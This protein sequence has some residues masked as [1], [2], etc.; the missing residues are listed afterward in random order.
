M[1]N[2]HIYI[3]GP[4][5]NKTNDVPIITLG[6]SIS[7]SGNLNTHVWTKVLQNYKYLVKDPTICKQ[8]SIS[9]LIYS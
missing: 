8:H 2:K 6:N 4:K 1:S 7:T 5:F 3:N 9:T